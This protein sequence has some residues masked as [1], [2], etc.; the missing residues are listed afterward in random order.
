[1]RGYIT[2]VT[3]TSLWHFYARG[4]R[5]IY[6]HQ[7]R[8]GIAKNTVLDHAIVTPTTKAEGGAH[9]EPLSCAGVVER[10]LL[11]RRLWETVQDVALSLYE[12][13]AK[14]AASAGLILADTKYEFGLSRSGDLLLIDEVHTPDSSRYW[15]AASYEE[16]LAAGGEPESLDKEIVR[17]AYAVTAIHLVCRRTCGR[18]RARAT[19]KRSRP[20]PPPRSTAVHI[21]SNLG[22]SPTSPRKASCER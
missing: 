20:S 13:G 14:V 11:D 10:G 2:G 16:R 17:R 18:K 12:R 19:S 8:D 1:M 7:F 6:G 21:R 3:T 9:D 4:D 15:V 22:L 5:E